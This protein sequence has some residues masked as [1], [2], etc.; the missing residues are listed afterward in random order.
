MISISMGRTSILIRAIGSRNK[1]QDLDDG[2]S[3]LTTP[4]EATSRRNNED[5]RRNRERVFVIQ[6]F[7]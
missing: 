6:R 7:K 2:E 3:Y 1:L 5:Q 4:R